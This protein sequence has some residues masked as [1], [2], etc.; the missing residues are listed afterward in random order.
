MKSIVK[1][2]VKSI[3]A[4]PNPL[5][6]NQ[7][8]TVDAASLPEAELQNAVITMYNLQGSKVFEL[9]KIESLNKL[10]LHIPVGIYVAK[11]VT[12]TG[13]EHNFEVAVGQ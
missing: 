7:T 5:K 4:Y 8:F 9:K 11:L 10:D 12:S 3:F 6:V 2:K 13:V 1:S